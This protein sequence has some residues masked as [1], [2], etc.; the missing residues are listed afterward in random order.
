[1]GCDITKNRGRQCKNK[2]GGLEIIY[3]FP[4]TKHAKSLIVKDGLILTG[5]PTTFI[6]SFAI[7]SG[8]YSESSEVDGGGELMN[9]TLTCTMT[10]LNEDNEWR[11]LLKKDHCL[12]AKDRNGKFRLM[13][14]Y[15][16]V[17]T[18]YQA[19][20]GSGHADFNGYT[21]NFKGKEQDEALYFDDLVGVGF[22]F[23]VV[24]SGEDA[25]NNFVFQDGNNFV[26]QDD[27]N[28]IFN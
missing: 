7:A 5:Y 10:H 4:Y 12:I 16:G 3:I 24:G 19:T 9:Q 14:V 2:L 21:F 8:E 22:E 1:M 11:K 27:N 15:N 28:F 13:G 18:D 6:Y 17:E 26:F 20:T 23:I 25:G